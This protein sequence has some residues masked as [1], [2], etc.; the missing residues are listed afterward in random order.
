MKTVIVMIVVLL[1]AGCSTRTVVETVRV[2]IPVP[3]QCVERTNIPPSPPSAL[4]VITIEST[5]GDKIKAI[6]VERE[7]LRQSDNELRALIQGCLL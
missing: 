6:L 1:L 2:N 5:P 4:K 7:Q 3:I